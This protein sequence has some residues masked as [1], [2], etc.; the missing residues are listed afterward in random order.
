VRATSTYDYN[1]SGTATVAVINDSPKVTNVSVYPN[2]VSVVKGTPQ[3]FTA[4]VIGSNNPSQAVTW[5]IIGGSSSGTG[6]TP[7]GI[8]LVAV[9]ESA[10]T[11]TVQATSVE[12]QSKKGS[13]TVTNSSQPVIPKVTKINISPANTSIIRGHTQQ[14]SA[15]VEGTNLPSQTVSWSLLGSVDNGTNVSSNGLL[16]VA[17]NEVATNL[18]LTATSTIDPSKSE[19]VTVTVRNDAPTI[20]RV[21]IYPNTVSLVKGDTQQFTAAVSGPNS[22][23]QTI[24]WSV[25]GAS[26]SGTGISSNGVLVVAINETATSLTVQATSTDDPSKKDSAIVTFRQAVSDVSATEIAPE[27][28][29]PPIVIATP[30]QRTLDFTD[31]SPRDIRG[32]GPAGGYIFYDK[33]RYSDGWRYLEAAPSHTEFTAAWGLYGSL[34]PDTSTDIGAGLANTTNIIKL[35]KANK[36]TDTAAQLCDA[37]TINGYDDWFLPSRD[38]LNEMYIRLRSGRNEGHFEVDGLW[39]GGYYWSSSV[40]YSVNNDSFSKFYTWYQ[41]FSDGFRPDLSYY[42]LNDY[43][44]APMRVRAVRRF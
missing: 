21:D 6:I 40:I 31:V 34:C 35:L 25:T 14:F 32:D 9:N 24:T 30:P 37:L 4:T 42:G 26:S 38:E 13:A 23:P 18:L 36:E 7:S 19:T 27:V 3:Q 29:V 22:P 20:I 33:G 10:T 12:D 2:A 44:T 28:V 43:R 41:R 8:L 15:T 11:L 39:P 17:I 1:K 16:Q 5:T